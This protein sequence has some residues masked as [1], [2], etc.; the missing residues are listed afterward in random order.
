MLGLVI[1]GVGEWRL[2]HLLLDVNGTLARD[3]ALLDGVAERVARLRAQL[4]VELLSADT[5]G[6][7]DALAQQLGVPG[8]RLPPG[9]PEAASKRARV[10]ALGAA[11]VAAIGNGANDV[12]MLRAAAVGI[13]VLGP[14]GLASAALVAADV[15]VPCIQDALDLLLYPRRLVATLRR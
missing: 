3:G 1:P 4:A 6:T 2:T 12:E 5:H 14:E 8:H 7:L 10:E 9:A 11:Q 13:A 15:V